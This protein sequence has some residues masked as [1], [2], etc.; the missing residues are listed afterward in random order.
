M[1]F[2][3]GHGTGNDFVIVPDVDGALDLT[4]ERVARLCDRRQ[5]VGGDG[6]LRVVRTA[7]HPDAADQ[8][9]EAEW[10]MDYFNADGSYAQMCGN[11]VRVFV[12]Y[13]LETGL[14]EGPE[15]PVATRAGVRR[16]LVDGSDLRVDMGAPR[17]LG[18][19]VATLGG[20]EY[21]GVGVDMGNPHL[22]C[23]VDSLDALDLTRAPGFDRNLYPG[24]VNV[25]FTEG[26][27]MRVYERGV[28]ET[29][30]CGT[31]A[32][33]VAVVALKG[34][35]GSTPVLVRGG[36]LTV[37][38]DGETCWLAGPAVIVAHGELSSGF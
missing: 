8:A 19:S 14:A 33:A 17:L 24:G 18:P 38:L 1:R 20:V 31:G 27:R 29:D 21:A 9:G 7:K 23:A 12:R 11:G 34:A 4:P 36:T 30:S 22:V 2:A 15:I 13:L 26:T 32:C 16:T 28:G 35:V 25:E 10:F 37:T 6:L 5:G 3:K